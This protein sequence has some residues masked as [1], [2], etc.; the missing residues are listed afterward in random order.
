MFN[1]F[2]FEYP[3]FLLLI[4]LFVICSIY[5]KAKAPSYFMPHLDIF[6][7]VNQKSSYIMSLL[8]YFVIVFSVIALSSPVKIN[9]TILLENDE[10]NNHLMILKDYLFF[11]PLFFAVI[12]LII[13]IYLRNKE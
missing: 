2:T 4:V 7:K 3:Y 1:N 8:K 6:N 9:D 5:C 10:I 11:Y 13:L 12:S